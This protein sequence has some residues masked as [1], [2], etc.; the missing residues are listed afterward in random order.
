M[1]DIGKYK[2]ESIDAIKSLKK[3]KGSLYE[4]VSK[5]MVQLDEDANPQIV[6][7]ITE[8]FGEMKEGDPRKGYITFDMYMQC[9]RIIRLAGQAKASVVLEREFV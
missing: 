9:I 6:R 7:S 8:I 3:I 1:S 4:D 2:D 5:V